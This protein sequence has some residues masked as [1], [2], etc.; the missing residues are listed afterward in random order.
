MW[1]ANGIPKGRAVPALLS[2]IYS[3]NIILFYFG[4]DGTC[5]FQRTAD[6]SKSF[7]KFLSK[8]KYKAENIS[9]NFITQNINK[10][11]LYVCSKWANYVLCRT[12]ATFT[13]F[14]KNWPKHNKKESD[15]IIFKIANYIMI[16]LNLFMRKWR[17]K[18]KTA[19][20]SKSSEMISRK[21]KWIQIRK[22]HH[23]C[24]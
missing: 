18:H 20:D 19:L 16:H 10:N 1:N 5:H 21:T 2:I 7:A 24:S 3:N 6:F 22:T 12:W 14:C 23:F 8:K 9:L 11:E 13:F 15:R 4:Q 17:R